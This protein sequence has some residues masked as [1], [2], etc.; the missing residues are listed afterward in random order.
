MVQRPSSFTLLP[1]HTLRDI[2]LYNSV[3]TMEPEESDEHFLHFHVV[4]PPIVASQ[5]CRSW[6]YALLSDSMMWTCISMPDMKP[7]CIME[8]LRRSGPSLLNVFIK[9]QNDHRLGCHGTLS[10]LSAV[11]LEI[12]R[13][14]V[15]HLQV[16]PGIFCGPQLEPGVLG[17]M[18]QRALSYLKRPAPKLQTFFAWYSDAL[19]G[20]DETKFLKTLFSKNAPNLKHIHHRLSHDI[21]DCSLFYNLTELHLALFGLHPIDSGRFLNLLRASPRLKLLRV[22]NSWDWHRGLPIVKVSSRHRVKLPHLQILVL[23]VNYAVALLLLVFKHVT[24]PSNVKWQITARYKSVSRMLRYVPRVPFTSLHIELTDVLALTFRERSS[25]DYINHFK[26]NKLVYRYEDFI[27]LMDFWDPL[28]EFIESLNI[29]HLSY[30]VDPPYYISPE[31]LFEFDATRTII[32]PLSGNLESLTI[33][34]KKKDDDEDDTSSDGKDDSS[35]SYLT[36]FIPNLGA[37]LA[38]EYSMN[39]TTADNINSNATQDPD[40]GLVPTSWGGCRFINPK[41]VAS[42][43]TSVFPYPRLQELHV[44]LPG[45]LKEIDA[46]MLC[47]CVS[48][49]RREGYPLRIFVRCAEI[50]ESAKS[51]LERDDVRASVDLVTV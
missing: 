13:F 7:S 5:V 50:K 28:K 10:T 1:Y 18:I 35:L 46:V 6:R 20:L 25:P 17:G 2:I 32:A 40:L 45:A 8:L 9:L 39:T 23:E 34:F 30:E 48:T 16:N 41:L 15:L 49:R 4:S 51:I 37:S 26:H 21:V 43:G 14:K 29:T 36:E 12:H 47:A 42:T 19:E 24:F 38:L 31:D 11:F 44:E 33:T 27:D 3:Y 22:H